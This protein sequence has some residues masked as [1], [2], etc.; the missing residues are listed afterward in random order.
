MLLTRRSIKHSLNRCNLSGAF[1]GRIP[2]T[3]TSSRRSI[4]TPSQPPPN[5]VIFSGIQPTGIPHLG[6]YLGALQQWV[7]LQ[8]TAA[9][10]TKLLYSIVDLHAITLPQD[11]QKLRQWK[12]E[13]LATLL[14]IG[15]DP[16]RS[17]LFHQS[18]VFAHT[19]LMWILS[20]TASMGYLSRM[21]QWKS[22][23]SLTDDTSPLEESAKSKLKLGLFSYPVL[24]A[25]DILVHRATHVP[26]GEDQS[27]HLEFARECVTNFNHAYGPHLIAPKTI[28]SPAKRVMSLQEPHLKMSKSHVD[29]RSRILI[30]D[31]PEIIY[32]KLMSALTD[33]TNSISYDPVARP[34]VSNLLELLSH[35]DAEG[36]DAQ[37]LAVVY[38][39]LGLG[40]FKKV[41]ATTISESLAG[42]REKYAQ[43]LNQDGGAYLDHVEREGARR[44]RENANATMAIVRE[45]VG[46]SDHSVL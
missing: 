8:N 23:L 30:T 10:S 25:A 15:L 13:G 44:A 40:Q 29:P 41:V 11:A 6:N 4:S 32:K 22:K 33:S 18:S 38:G 26:V 7:K 24:Q 14:A 21:T 46:L 35:F 1:A 3:T 12:R 20:C 37:K 45:A 43:V 31:T 42:I 34:G 16:E 36:R 19:E 17:I 9:P 27:Q 2:I 28:M 39:D 5:Q